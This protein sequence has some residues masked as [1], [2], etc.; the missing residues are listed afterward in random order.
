MTGVISVS[1]DVRA[2]TVKQAWA[3][4]VCAVASGIPT[5]W[6]YLVGEEGILVSSSLEMAQRGDWLRLWLYGTNAVHG[7]FANWLVILLAS[8]VGWEHAPGVVRA[9]MMVATACGG[10]IAAFVEI[11]RASCRERV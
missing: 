11:G 9:I 8:V 7:V 1:N 6:F 10:L 2:S 4:Y 3:L 5:L